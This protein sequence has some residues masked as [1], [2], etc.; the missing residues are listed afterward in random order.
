MNAYVMKKH[1][2]H[3]L[4]LNDKSADL[5]AFVESYFEFHAAYFAAINQIGTKELSFQNFI[6]SALGYTE[7]SIVHLFASC[8]RTVCAQFE[9]RVNH[10]NFFSLKEAL[11]KDFKRKIINSLQKECITLLK[12]EARL[13]LNSSTDI[14]SLDTFKLREY[15]KAIIDANFKKLS[16]MPIPKSKINIPNLKN[17]M[18]LPESLKR[19][20]DILQHAHELEFSL[21]SG[22]LNRLDF[23]LE[24]ELPSKAKKL[25][26]RYRSRTNGLDLDIFSEKINKLVDGTTSIYLLYDILILMIDNYWDDI[27]FMKRNFELLHDILQIKDNQSSSRSDIPALIEQLAHEYERYEDANDFKNRICDVFRS[28]ENEPVSSQVML[29]R[30]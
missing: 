24:E 1:R 18:V 16:A 3:L 7:E 9:S 30:R 5:N 14:R 26:R 21:P 28:H 19:F 27:K 25:L 17:N 10:H 13:Y 15:C 2:H 8:F 20:I 4:A 29:F 23:K 11:E 22:L 12:T 6:D